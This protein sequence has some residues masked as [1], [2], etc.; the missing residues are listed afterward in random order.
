MNRIFFLLITLCSSYIGL[1]AQDNETPFMTKSFSKE[2]ISSVTLNTSGG[3]LR[4]FGVDDGQA[5]VEVF[6]QSGNGKKNLSKEDIQKKLDNDY[7]L[8][9]EV[10]G[11][12]LKASAKPKSRI[13]N[14]NDALSISFRAYVPKNAHASMNTSGGS[15]AVEALTANV[16]ANTSGGS[17]RLSNIQG[18]VNMT[19]SGG[20]IKADNSN[21]KISLVTSGGSINLAS[22]KGTINAVTSGGSIKADKVQGELISSTSGGSIQVDNMEGSVD[23][24]TS[25]GSARVNMLAVEKYVKIG[26]S[27]GSVSLSLP[28]DKGL[29]LDLNARNVKTPTLTN[30]TGK[31]EKNLVKGQINGGGIPITVDVSVGS[32]TLSGN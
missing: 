13:R 14:W 30:F 18:N 9:I 5:R 20:S 11:G 24:A 8:T 7:D 1:R 10:K 4:V 19:T 17:I 29:D 28:M 22:L 16:E 27:A 25:A 32:L 26:V 3:S 21:G 15:I 23:L 31:K 12:E 6:V 2:Q